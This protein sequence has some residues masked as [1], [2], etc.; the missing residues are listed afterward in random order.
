ML[1]HRQKKMVV[2]SDIDKTLCND[3]WREVLVLE[4]PKRWE[5]YYAGIVMDP[6]YPQ[7]VDLVTQFFKT[8]MEVTFVTGRPDKYRDASLKWLHKHVHTH[9]G[10]GYN[11][12]LGSH[13]FMRD[14]GDRR[15]NHEVK[16]DYLRRTPLK[17]WPDLVIEDEPKCIWMFR[18]CG[19]VVLD[20]K[21]I[22]GQHRLIKEECVGR[23][24]GRD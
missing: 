23:V 7:V 1:Y 15:P 16:E 9:C 8:A 10:M 17:K 21:L 4:D 5:E 24:A 3:S 19:V 12:R 13:L 18:N 6:P 11:R 20:A 2:W 22:N 14:E